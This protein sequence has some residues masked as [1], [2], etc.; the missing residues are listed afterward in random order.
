MKVNSTNAFRFIVDT[1]PGSEYNRSLF[2]NLKHP[3]H[4]FVFQLFPRSDL[5]AYMFS[6][7]YRNARKTSFYKVR[8]L[9]TGVLTAMCPTR[10]KNFESFGASNKTI[11]LQIY[12]YR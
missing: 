3:T 7:L 12:S 1:L 2:L 8:T 10:R 5:S 9:M 4:Q 6:V 11:G